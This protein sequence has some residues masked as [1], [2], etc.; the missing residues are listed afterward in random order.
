[1][2]GDEEYLMSNN[3]EDN[4]SSTGDK[5]EGDTTTLSQEDDLIQ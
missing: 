3:R 2:V 1:M 5:S 4:D